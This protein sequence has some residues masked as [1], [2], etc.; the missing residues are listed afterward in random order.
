MVNVMRIT[1]RKTRSTWCWTVHYSG[2]GS[3]GSNY[4]GPAWIALQ[5]AM[6]SLQLLSTVELVINNR[7]MRVYIP[8]EKDEKTCKGIVAHVVRHGKE[9]A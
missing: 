7:M 4:C 2:G 1:M 5:N 8:S 3:F 9:I 6:R